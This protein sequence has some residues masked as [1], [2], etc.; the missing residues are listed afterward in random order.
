MKNCGRREAKPSSVEARAGAGIGFM[1]AGRGMIVNPIKGCKKK[2][3]HRYLT[4][5][6]VRGSDVAKGRTDQLID[7]EVEMSRADGI[8]VD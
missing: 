1:S 2:Q 6:I 5:V 3:S 4:D 7:E 8:T